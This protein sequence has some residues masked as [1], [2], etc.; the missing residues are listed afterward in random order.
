MPKPFLLRRSSGLYVRYW[1]PLLLRQ[2][3]GSDTIV[4][5]LGRLRGDAAR[6][7]AARLGYALSHRFNAMKREM[8]PR[9]IAPP[10]STL[11]ECIDGYLSD[12][13]AARRPL[14]LFLALAGDKPMSA[15]SGEDVDTFA[16]ALYG[17]PR[18]AGRRALFKQVSPQ[19]VIARA[20]RAEA[21]PIGLETWQRYL[22]ALR[23]FAKWMIAHA[24]LDPAFIY[25]FDRW[26]GPTVSPQSDSLPADVTTHAG[27]YTVDRS[28]DGSLRIHADTT[29]DHAHVLDVL[30]RIER[31]HLPPASAKVARTLGEARDLFLVQFKE[32]NPAPATVHETK[33]TLALFVDVIGAAKP[34]NEVGVED[35]DALRATLA[36]WPARARVLPDYKGLSTRDIIKKAKR[37]KSPGINVRTKDKHLDNV[38]KFF[39]WAVQRHEMT[40]NPL[41]GV[42]LQTKAQ[43]ATLTR[44]GFTQPE[45]AAL[46]APRLRAAHASTPSCF[47]LPILALHTGAR[48]RELAQL[49]VVDVHEVGGVWGLD[50][51][52]HAGPLKNTQSQRFVPL[53]SA[54]A[55]L[56]F[57]A[58]VDDV[59]TAGFDRV[60]PDGSWT[61][62]NGPGD[63][64]SKWFN[65][66]YTRAA[67]LTDPALVFHSFR[68][69]VA[70][71]VDGV[72]LTEA[73]IGAITGHQSNS[74]LGQH[75]IRRKT[76]VVRH[77]HVD[78]IADQF[79]LPTQDVYVAGQFAE[80]FAELKKKQARAGALIAR[81]ARQTKKSKK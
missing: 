46:F 30:D 48:L 21:E 47:W 73:Q 80:A 44:R 18:D 72:G 76:V 27:A 57:L 15:F 63:K 75:Y 1:V 51:N 37:D 17:W 35:V 33:A 32:R 10:S 14:Q 25:A 77:Q 6:L 62:K 53:A 42:R 81:A 66:G 12:H 65:R 67:G 74:V 68:H 4:R 45:L 16:R 40:H 70:D 71:T 3:V 64:V 5:S 9:M 43:K 20:K 49:R 59:R 28:A 55:A 54:M 13:S 31:Q 41:S 78:A 61:A 22:S 69:T 52:Y 26:L 38:R 29:E 24:K 2:A 60:F 36:V 11:G 19:E 79:K 8:Q 23:A 34:M 7:E 50:I 39:G 56:G 58:Y